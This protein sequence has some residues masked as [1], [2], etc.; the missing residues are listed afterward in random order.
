MAKRPPAGRC[1]HC[2][3]K[4]DNLT[5]DHV[6]PDSWYPKGK[7]NLKK[8]EVP[9]CETCNRELGKIEEELLTKFGLTLDPR[10]LC[11]FGI[12]EKVLRSLNPLY[13]KNERDRTRRQ[14]KREK[15]L[16]HVVA[17]KK[18]PDQVVFPNFGPLPDYE[19]KEFPSVFIDPNYVDK[20]AKKIVRGIAYVANKSYI[21]DDY[22]MK[23]LI[24]DELKAK[25]MNKLVNERG[26]TFDRGH[27]FL[28]K[29]LLVGNDLVG[30]IYFIEIWGRLRFYV[31]VSPKDQTNGVVST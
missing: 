31:V 20:F 28:V 27:A 23:L 10:E 16:K 19:Y 6:L 11:S 21:E 17:Y 18:L 8:W 24:V 5:W 12:P 13:G 7:Y 25:E 4:F 26:E 22:D 3:K 15:I 14:R 29:R 30:G 2:L 1:V 9:A